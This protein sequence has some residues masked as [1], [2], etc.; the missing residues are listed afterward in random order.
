M[1][2]DNSPSAVLRQMYDEL[3]KAEFGDVKELH[4][5]LIT[6]VSELDALETRVKKIEE[7][8]DRIE[9]STRY[10][11]VPIGSSGSLGNRN[12]EISTEVQDD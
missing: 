2:A 8:L 9:P 10:A 6:V 7:R 3:Q 4:N 1:G 12:F 11:T 5:V